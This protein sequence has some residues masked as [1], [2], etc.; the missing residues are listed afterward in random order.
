MIVDADIKLT[1]AE[2]TRFKSLFMQ[3]RKCA[4]HPFLFPGAERDFDGCTYETIVTSS[5]KF[6]VLDVLLRRL[7]LRGHRCVVFSQF[8]S[9][10]DL[11]GDFLE[12]RGHEFCRLDG[13]TNR[14]Q[15][16]VDIARFNKADSGTY[17][18]LLST[19]AGGLGVNLQTAD[20][21]IILD[22]DWNPQSDL[23]AM[24]RVHRIGQTKPVH[25]Y[26]LV[27][28][29][30]VEERMLQRQKRKLFLDGAVTRTSTMAAGAAAAAAARRPGDQEEEEGMSSSDL[31][32][33]VMFGAAASL[34]YLATHEDR[35]TTDGVKNACGNF[36]QAAGVFEAMREERF[37]VLPHPEV[38]EYV[39][40]KGDN[41]DR[42]LLGMQRL[43]KRTIEG[44]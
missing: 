35:G 25:V 20:T 2:V 18:Y 37:H 19:R 29:G 24:G 33:S 43:R 34:M 10:L 39:R 1:H 17:I 3:L 7:K 6:A 40:R 32:S 5:G 31:L 44:S 12:F 22:S 11:V 21:C 23:Q 30:T 8:T 26:R 13:S 4:I 36:Q 27:S 38:E 28:P 41:I 42:W 9:V 14:V 16:W 15:R